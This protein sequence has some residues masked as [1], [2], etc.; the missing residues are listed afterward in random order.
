MRRR[1]VA[2]RAVK[3]ET[4]AGTVQEGSARCALQDHVREFTRTGRV[5][6]VATHS[7]EQDPRNRRQ[8]AARQA[9]AQLERD[10]ERERQARGRD[11]GSGWGR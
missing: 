2:V 8:E 3:W 11:R 9:Q 10:H 5:V 7:G 6:Q 1:E 4:G